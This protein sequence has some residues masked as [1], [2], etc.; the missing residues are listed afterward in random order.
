V[1]LFIRGLNEYR[2]ANMTSKIQGDPT[3]SQARAE[4][5]CGNTKYWQLINSGEISVYKVGNQTRVFRESLDAYKE[6]HRFIP[7]AKVAVA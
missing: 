4:L 1:A 5:N 2:G 3:G 6:R 7:K